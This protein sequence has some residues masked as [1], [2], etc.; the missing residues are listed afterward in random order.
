MRRKKILILP[1]LCDRKGDITKK[2]FVELS[3][4]NHQTDEMTRCRFEMLDGININSFSTAIERK[5]FA[6]KIID[7]LLQKLKTGWTIFNDTARVVYEDQTQYSHEARVYKRMIDSN[8]NVVYWLSRYINEELNKSGLSAETLCTYTSRCRV[9]RLWIEAHKYSHIDI[10]AIDNSKIIEFFT[11]L[12]N[13]RHLAKRTYNSYIE[14]LIAFFEFVKKQSGLHDNPVHSL[15]EN[16]LI[17]DMGAERIRKEDLKIIIDE[18]DNHD[19]QLALACRFEYYCGLR[20]GYET[21]LLRIGDIDLRSGYSKVRVMATNAKKKCRRE[22]VIPD[23]FLDYLINEWKLNEYSKDFYVFGKNGIPGAKHL[24][25]NNMRFRFNK[26]REKLNMPL[27]YKF[28][29]FKHTGATMLAEQGEPII[30]IR[31]HL[32]HKSIAT[33]EHYL[34][35]HGANNSQTIRKNFPK[36]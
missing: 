20:P 16:K 26:I 7:D 15:P 35:R 13:E 28:Y 1:K 6:Q 24:G 18:M 12:R 29:S 30:N 8:L 22:V 10:T 36:I 31:D 33:T 21:R 34:N 11:Y 19:R 32:G 27:E 5:Q 23:D 2:W 14:I 9:F 17:K 25:K 3:Q 4:R